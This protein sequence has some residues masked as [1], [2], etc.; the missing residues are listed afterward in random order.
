VKTI[1]LM[2]HS[3]AGE[4]SS[5]QT[6]FERSLTDKGMEKA[7]RTGSCLKS[8]GI[9]IDRIVASSA[10]RTKQTAEI[11]AAEACPSVPINL[12]DELYLAPA[13]AFARS[14]REQPCDDESCVLVVGHNPGIASLMC[15]WSHEDLAVPTSTL[16]LFFSAAVDWKSVRSGTAAAPSLQCVIHKGQVVWQEP[17]FGIPVVP[18]F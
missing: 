5:S 4:G 8:I 11:V 9:R 16:A 15:Q 14:V 18:E 7:R 6:D 2:R 17:S 13:D 3:K 10:I 12:L 1:L